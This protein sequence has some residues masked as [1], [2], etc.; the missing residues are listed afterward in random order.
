MAK[1]LKMQARP[2][3]RNR[4]GGEGKVNKSLKTLVFI[5]NVC[6]GSPQRGEESP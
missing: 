6:V 4:A 2:S 1:T 5:K 3:R